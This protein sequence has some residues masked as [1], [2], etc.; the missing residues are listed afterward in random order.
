MSRGEFNLFI[1]S[2]EETTGVRKN[3][4]QLERVPV[5]KTSRSVDTGLED[6][7]DCEDSNIM[8]TILEDSMTKSAPIVP[9]AVIY[10][11]LNKSDR[12]VKISEEPEM[13]EKTSTSVEIEKSANATNATSESIASITESESLER[14]RSEHLV[15][16]DEAPG[17]SFREYNSQ[18]F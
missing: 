10:Q 9:V 13:F 6:E 3:S 8:N 12:P 5:L 7:L 11:P 18:S 15:L 16:D 1:H 17:S 2:E 4:C 14:D